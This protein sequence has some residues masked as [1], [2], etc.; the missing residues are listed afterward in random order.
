[1]GVLNLNHVQ[2]WIGLLNCKLTSL[3]QN[4]ASREQNLQ[5]EKGMPK[6]RANQTT[7]PALPRRFPQPFLLRDHPTLLHNSIFLHYISLLHYPTFYIVS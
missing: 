2:V 1:M 6:P 5:K 7:K 4:A 3:L